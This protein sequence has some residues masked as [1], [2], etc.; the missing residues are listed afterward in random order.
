MEETLLTI[1]RLARRTG[2]TVRN[3]RAHQ[4]RGLLPPPRVVGRTGYYGPDHVARLEFIK[5]MQEAGFNLSGIK[6]VLDAVAPGAGRELLEF[7]RLLMAPWGDEEPEI[8]SAAELAERFGELDERVLRRAEALGVV[9]PLP[10]GRY[11]V[12]SPALLKAGQEVVSLGIPLDHALAVTEEVTR[13]ARGVAKQFVRL[14]LNDVWR[15]FTEAGLPESEL[16]A[17]RRSLQRL[18]ALAA[19][20]LLTTFR[21]NMADEVEEAFGK[22]LEGPLGDRR[23]RARGGAA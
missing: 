7:E 13:H 10:G 16:P 11:E 9:R 3:I 5:E 23:E 19:D 4:T 14:F 1:D 2:M 6:R 12:P 18:R 21:L 8:V 20:V 22:E 15:P 17:V